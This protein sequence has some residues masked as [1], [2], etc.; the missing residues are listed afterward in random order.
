MDYS[1]DKDVK[2]VV[3]SDLFVDIYKNFNVTSQVDKMNQLSKKE[4]YLLLTVCL[5]KHSDEDQVVVHNFTPFKDECMT[6][7]DVQDDKEVNDIDLKSLVDETG[8]KYIETDFIVNSKGES[9]PN[10]LTKE[11]VRDARIDIINEK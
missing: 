5:D 3:V 6:I 2:K 7:F 10:P 11:E 9:L 1:N 8:D 4:L